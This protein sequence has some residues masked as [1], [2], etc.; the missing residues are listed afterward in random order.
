M[1]DTFRPI[2][3]LVRTT[4]EPSPTATTE[5]IFSTTFYDTTETVTSF[6]T[7]EPKEIGTTEQNDEHNKIL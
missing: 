5:E 7:T 3:K 4:S 1:F 2:E 6:T